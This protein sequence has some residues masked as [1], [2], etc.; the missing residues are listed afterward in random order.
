VN[1]S[2]NFNYYGYL[3]VSSRS[4][5]AA[6][7]VIRHHPAIYARAVG[8]SWRIYLAAPG[9]YAALVPNHDHI[10][11]V[12]DVWRVAGYGE[13]PNGLTV[14]NPWE[15]RVANIGWWVV[16]SFALILVGGFAA[17]TRRPRRLA[18]AV[19]SRAAGL[20]GISVVLL[21]PIAVNATETLENNRFRYEVE[22]LQV[23]LAVWLVAT[24][25]HVRRSTER[26]TERVTGRDD[27]PAA[28]AGA[29]R[30]VRPSAT[31]DRYGS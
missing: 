26:Q 29:S 13:L 19:R 1:G 24:W 31:Y 6:L 11:G 23:V 30:A 5:H 21:F 16:A 17:L 10:A 27:A 12:D 9:K 14:K 22:P 28:G 7:D 25:W 15:I 20:F 18:D 2:A 8:D 4:L 3:D